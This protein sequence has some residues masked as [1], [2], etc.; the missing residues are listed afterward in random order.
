MNRLDDRMRQSEV[1]APKWLIAWAG[2]VT[3]SPIWYK[4]IGA[5]GEKKQ[6]KGLTMSWTM[7]FSGLIKLCPAVILGECLR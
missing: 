5:L 3:G 6:S 2:D 1:D 7:V 4:G